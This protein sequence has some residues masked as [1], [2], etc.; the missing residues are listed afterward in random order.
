MS[1]DQGWFESDE[2]YARRVAREANERT[3][4]DASGSGP[5]QGWLESDD[6]YEARITKG[7]KRIPH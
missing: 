3:I 1:S 7:G 4:E 6:E 5:S 2:D